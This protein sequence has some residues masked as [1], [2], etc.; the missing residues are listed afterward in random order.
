MSNSSD[1]KQQKL[2][3]E[4]VEFY[5]QHS[6]GYDA[7]RWTSPA[8]QYLNDVQIGVVREMVATG[9]GQHHLDIA[10]GTGRFAVDLAVCGAKVVALD[11][12]PGM[13]A[14]TNKRAQN[15][16]VSERVDTRQGFANEMGL[17]DQF[18]TCT[19]MNAL[20]HI[21]DQAGVIQS[22]AEALKDDGIFVTSYTNW[23]SFYL[24]LGIYITLKGKS[25][26]GDV[27]TKWFSLPGIRKLHSENGFEVLEVQGVLHIPTRIKNRHLLNILKGLDR[28]CRKSI[29]RFLAPQLFVKARKT[30][31]D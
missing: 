22:A 18:D 29:F 3:N 9:D 20:C 17:K 15:S 30:S 5:E 11:S 4:S 26:H 7:K 25:I 24:P 1:A 28:L 2:Y 14:E 31:T 12:S 19:C 10:T 16:N 21:P 13:L 27:Y 8:G 6:E 23:F